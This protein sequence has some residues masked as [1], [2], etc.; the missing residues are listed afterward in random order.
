MCTVS[1]GAK[2]IENT[3]NYFSKIVNYNPPVNVWIFEDIEGSHNCDFHNLSVLTL[4]PKSTQL[5]QATVHCR[6]NCWKK[7]PTN[8]EKNCQFAV[9]NYINSRH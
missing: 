3:Y 7:H 9:S 8:V 2:N 1:R 6:Y 4:C 5:V